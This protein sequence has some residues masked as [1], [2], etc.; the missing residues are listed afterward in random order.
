MVGNHSVAANRRVLAPIFVD[1]ELGMMVARL[2]Q[3]SLAALARTM[4]DGKVSPVLDRRHALAGVPE[5]IRYSET[6][7]ARGKFKGTECSRRVN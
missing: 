4:E 7:R 1:Q 3:D 2:R 5:A 6:G